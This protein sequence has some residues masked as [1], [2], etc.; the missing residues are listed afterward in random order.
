V[1]IFISPI[2]AAFILFSS[3]AF[4]EEISFKSQ[5][6]YFKASKSKEKLDYSD[7]Q[8]ARSLEVKSCN[9]VVIEK[10][11]SEMLQNLKGL[12]LVQNQSKPTA[13]SKGTAIYSGIKYGL[14][15]FE[16][17]YSFFSRV[18]KNIHV[19]FSESKRACREK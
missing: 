15:E 3:V 8:G 4:G 13:V 19:V 5:G 12:Q 16:P 7:S 14:L 6:H 2:L 9:R 18:P 11:W 10:F 1:R 17:A